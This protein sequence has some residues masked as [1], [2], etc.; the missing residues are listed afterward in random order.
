MLLLSYPYNDPEMVRLV[1]LKK[2]PP[3][4][5]A[6]WGT[7]A[8]HAGHRNTM[9]TLRTDVVPTYKKIRGMFSVISTAQAKTENTL[10]RPSTQLRGIPV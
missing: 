7:Q 3:G 10:H 8:S 2:S 1:T 4:Y 6:E 9:E 5:T